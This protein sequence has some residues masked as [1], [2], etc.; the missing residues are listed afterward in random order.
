MRKINHF[1]DFIFESKKKD[2]KEILKSKIEE[3]KELVD[4]NSVMGN[5]DRIEFLD[6]IKENLQ[7]LAPE[8]YDVYYEEEVVFDNYLS[9]KESIF[10]DISY[11]TNYYRKYSNLTNWL[12]KN[13]AKNIKVKVYYNVDFILH[14]EGHL[15][16]NLYDIYERDFI[17]EL[18]NSIKIFKDLN[19]EVENYTS[20][21]YVF[22]AIKELEFDISDIKTL[23][24]SD[25]V[26]KEIL[27]DFE[28]FIIKK[29]LKKSDAEEIVKIFSKINK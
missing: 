6:T 11:Y 24:L 29:N 14:T 26:P 20:S 23:D 12:N 8:G 7:D 10:L 5:M 4:N 21:P 3:F 1:N 16:R 25:I 19:F 27:D 22:G 28:K 13:I 17:N 18:E 9:G 2:W 15:V